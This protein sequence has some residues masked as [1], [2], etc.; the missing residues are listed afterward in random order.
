MTSAAVISARKSITENDLP[1]AD[2][3]GDLMRYVRVAEL[4][5][6]FAPLPDRLDS[7]RRGRSGRRLAPRRRHVPVILVG[8]S[9]SANQKWSFEPR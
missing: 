8:T 9:Y 7:F 4:R 2:H 1:V 5:R 3:C 6:A